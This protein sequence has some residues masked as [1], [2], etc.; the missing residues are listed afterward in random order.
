M[1]TTTILRSTILRNY[2]LL[3]LLLTCFSGYLAA[4][5]ILGIAD[6]QAGTGEE[7]AVSI[8][9]SNQEPV[10]AFQMDVP[11]PEAFTYVGSSAQINPQRGSNHQLSALLLSQNVLRIICFS[12]DNSPFTGNSGEVVSFELTAGNTP[13][14]YILPVENA[15]VSNQ[16]GVNVLTGTYNATLQ[17]TG[18]KLS[19]IRS[20]GFGSVALE[21]SAI[22]ELNLINVGQDNLIIESISFSNS[23]FSS[24]AVFPLTIEPFR[25]HTIT[26]GFLASEAGE[27][28][29]T[30]SI[31]SNDPLENPFVVELSA[32]VFSPNYI[33][34]VDLT[35]Q[36]AGNDLLEISIE[37]FDAFTAFQFDLLLPE[38]VSY[39]PAS[40]VLNPIRVQ[41]HSLVV[42]DLG[43]N[44]LR[45]LAYSLSQSPF[46]GNDGVILSLGIELNLTPPFAPLPVLLSNGILANSQAQNILWGL[47][48]GFISVIDFDIHA[49]AG[50]N[51]VISPSGL[52]SVYYGTDQEFLIV[53]DS[54]Y[55]IADVIVDGESVGAPATYTFTNVTQNHTIEAYFSIQTFTIS[56]T[57]DGSGTIS[58]S[59][60]VTVEYG[61][62]QT[63][64]IVPDTGHDIAD[65]FVNGE[66]I[67]AVSS[68]TF[69]NI[70]DDQTIHAVFSIQTFT[71]TAEAGDN[72]SI[73]P[74]GLL[75]FEYGMSQVFEIVPDEYYKIANVV[76]DGVSVGAVSSFEFENISEN[77]T[78]Y[79]T[80]TLM[81]YTI[82]ASADENGTITP[83]GKIIFEHGSSQLY[84]ISPAPHYSILD[85]FVDGESV[86]PVNRYFFEDISASHVIHATFVIDNYPINA[87]AGSNG[88]ISPS[89]EV[90]VDHGSDQLFAITP[91]A[92]YHILD[93][94]VDKESVG[95]VEQFEFINVT[96]PH[97]IHAVFTINTFT[98]TAI[99]GE[100]G[101]INPEGTITLPY[102]SEQ[103]YAI[104]PDFGY[105]IADVLVDGVSV[106]PSA[107][108]TFSNLDA[109][110]TIEAI[111]EIN[112]YYIYT[113]SSGNGTITPSGQID[114][115]HGQDQLFLI[116]PDPNHYIF[117][118]LVDNVSIGAVE[119]YLFEDV[120]SDHS[121]QAIFAINT[122]TINASAGAN[123][124]IAP[125]GAITVDYGSAQ[126]FAI[127]P[128]YGFQ[129]ADVIVD[130]LSA[131]AVEE[132]TFSE[133]DADHT[134]HAVF[135]TR[136]YT[137][138]A[139]AGENGSIT[140]S[141][142]VGVL[143]Q[144]SQQFI[145]SPDANY[146]IL[147]V[148]VD[149]VSVG[150]VNTYLFEGVVSDH[151]IQA[152][153]T[154]DT[155]TINAT[156]G[157]NGIISPS[158]AVTADYGT[159]LTFTITPDYGFQVADVLVDGVSVG[160]TE[161]YTFVGIDSDH[162]IHAVF[163]TRIYTITSSAGS[164]GTISPSG[165]VSVL[166]NE[167]QSFTI[168]P[169]ANH[170]I[171]DVLV[172]GV[173]VGVTDQY[174][175]NNVVSDHTIQALF[176]INTF[177]INAS[178]GLNG[179]ISPS[180]NVSV[181]YGSDKIFQ[182]I[183]D[184]GYHVLDVIV[185]GLSVG[186]RNTYTFLNVTE[187]H[188]I[189]V[190][191]ELNTYTIFAEASEFGTIS[192]AGE[193]SVLHGSD[194]RFE[195]TPDEEYIVTDVLINNISVGPS[196]RY[197]FISITG[198]QTIKVLFAPDTIYYDP[199]VLVY[200][201]P[202]VEEISVRLK[203]HKKPIDYDYQI[204]D[205]SGRMLITGRFNT[206]HNKVSLVV[207]SPGVYFLRIVDDSNVIKVI[208]IVKL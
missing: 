131:G 18:P 175:F 31:F 122:F 86:G 185:D 55:Q 58:P 130:G 106:G 207:L 88:S 155:F 160:Q 113:T 91:D 156:A 205:R 199:E 117:D 201:V 78:I 16:N 167:S 65:V 83:A 179:S 17:L 137:I 148:L 52:V 198:D 204:F 170:Y 193:I 114:V 51:G 13:G 168:I 190:S 22:K 102:G 11:I 1:K 116:T 54:R 21:A 82:A 161:V 25:Q 200:P 14:D 203:H 195:F 174:I 32:N 66:S 37:N 40:A 90:L 171:L 36:P 107:E 76:V 166:H 164:N 180:G 196:Q 112:T 53:P 48:S 184:D 147:D 34:V 136:V 129:V 42:T 206:I 35:T 158:G 77:H 125:M 92:N 4:Q 138:T 145:I 39:I 87:T 101:T 80:F 97:L 165:L 43:N 191:F 2:F 38:N 197:D 143:H 33:S 15:V 188:T 10:V 70:L 187:P 150:A 99:A 68:Y 139:S 30:M 194:Q 8:Q 202:A 75:T 104:I 89:G 63:F 142:E 157:I 5:N 178:A 12:A 46:N 103:T 93:V 118:V 24:N 153:F 44:L 119:Q 20:L 69:E 23:S 111:F 135:E 110:H 159:D 100:N 189:E 61:T 176:A 108:Y 81:T 56:A 141:G 29:A 26:I 186:A 45:V 47:N 183:P 109:D 151:T 124:T 96:G 208:K 123:G 163:E 9:L 41:D 169:D 98:I 79:A 140:P 95:P 152:F 19:A 72:G 7:V 172:D 85:V 162:T 6:A 64:E 84:S 28:S 127:L 132:Y 60:E 57:T 149:G 105:H 173:S 177:V 146:H 128:D 74:S 134:I 115:E 181:N 144:A 67:G 133:I 73:S 126:L 59:G 182:L 192:P 71:I 94:V 3:S 27:V 121:I 120:I 62:S 154:I 49:G 50:Q